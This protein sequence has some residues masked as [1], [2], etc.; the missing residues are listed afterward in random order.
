MR[1]WKE[2]GLVCM[3]I[4]LLVGLLSCAERPALDFDS[5]ERIMPQQPDGALLRLDTAHVDPL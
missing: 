3:W 1:N 5:I 2:N 4:S